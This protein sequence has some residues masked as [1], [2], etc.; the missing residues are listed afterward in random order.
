MVLLWRVHQANRASRFL[1]N[2]TESVLPSSKL[3]NITQRVPKGTGKGL[4]S[5]VC[6][7]DT[8][9]VVLSSDGLFLCH[10]LIN[11]KLVVYLNAAFF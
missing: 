3:F 7:C 10:S 8:D 6:I 9:V 1:K 11:L 2:V 4:W 5:S